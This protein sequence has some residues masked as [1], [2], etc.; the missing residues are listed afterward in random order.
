MIDVLIIGAGF[1]GLGA[2]IKLRM[3]GGYSFT[4]LEREQEIG[5]T[6]RDNTYPGCACDIPSLL[7]S[8]SFAPNPDWSKAFSPQ[9]EIL[10]YLKNCASQWDI[11]KDIQFNKEVISA[12]FIAD[13][14]VWKICCSD[15]SNYTS[16]VLISAAGPFN[17]PFIPKI[18]GRDSFKGEAF[19]SLNWNH[20]YDLKGK[21]VALLGTGASAI[22]ILPAIVDQVKSITVYQRT[23]PYI[24]PKN[25]TFNTE[26]TKLRF[27]KYPMYQRFW[28]EMVYWFLENIG[29][30]QYAKNSMRAKRKKDALAHLEAQIPDQL[31]REKLTPD[32]EF[33]CKRVLIS[34][35]YYPSF[36]KDN[37]ELVA[38]G[39]HRITENSIIT[40]SGVEREVDAII[41]ATGFYTTEYPNLYKMR[42]INGE[43][44]YDKF[45]KEG[46]EAYLGLTVAGYPNFAFIVGPNTGLGHN[47]IIHMMESQISYI[48]D[49]L[50]ILKSSPS[51][52]AYLDLKPHVQ[53]QF[54]EQIQE[55]LS[56]MVWSDGGCTSYYLKGQNGKNTSI[57][58]GSTVR[59][60]RET[61]KVH[62]DDYHL[63]NPVNYTQSN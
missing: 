35:E 40:K 48:L 47:S 44:L 17:A 28:R 12:D 24:A 20:D 3:A 13:Q 42:G 46:P 54:N 9:P 14:G 15:G 61:K 2:A 25:D 6:W 19:H 26:K 41:Y 52:S 36:M 50:K 27:K 31:L 57:W 37:V 58:P 30:A 60:R 23:A 34:D 4:I 11:N 10:N 39:A 53:R 38:E 59:Y 43:N 7:Y 33:G 63:I 8:Y 22:Q 45:N 55:R 56:T 29:R 1:A 18:E 49:Y 51:D 5:G 32:Y 21:R 16:R 62:R